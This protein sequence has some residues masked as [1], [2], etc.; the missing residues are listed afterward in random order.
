MA[1]DDDFE[2]AKNDV[3]DLSEMPSNQDQLAL[4]GLFKQAKFGDVTG[5]RPAQYDMFG[6]AKFDAWTKVKG[7][8]ADD[9][10]QQYIAKVTE[11]LEADE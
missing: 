11:L 10:K 7:M 4:Y 9:A 8:G 5:K 6:R 1:L 2:K 3:Q